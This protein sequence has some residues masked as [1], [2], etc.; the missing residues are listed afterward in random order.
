MCCA[1]RSMQSRAPVKLHGER[2]PACTAALR[3]LLSRV[4]CVTTKQ[5]ARPL[6]RDFLPS[7][8]S[9]Y[10]SA[11]CPCR[12]PVRR[13]PSL[14]VLLN[15]RRLHSHASFA[16]NNARS[17][18]RASSLRARLRRSPPGNQTGTRAD[19]RPEVS[20]NTPLLSSSRPRRDLATPLF[21]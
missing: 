9:C 8:V 20:N 7:R 21:F 6:L 18:T 17:A 13:R 15:A 19:R 10:R 1:K 12:H 4:A 5:V 14:Q 16:A 11:A 2:V 3:R